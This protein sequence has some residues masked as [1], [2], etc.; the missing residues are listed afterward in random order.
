MHFPLKRTMVVDDDPLWRSNYVRHLQAFRY[1]ATECENEV[2]A[3]AC[4]SST[5][6]HVALVHFSE[7]IA[8]SLALINAI[9]T[10][11]PTISAIYA[12]AYD[13]Q[14]VKM[15]AW[16]QGAFAVFN[17]QAANPRGLRILVDEAASHSDSLRNF[18]LEGDDVFVLMPF[19]ARFN[20]RY[21][22]GIKEPLERLGYRTVRA[23]EVHASCDIVDDIGRRIAA[24]RFVVADMTGGNANV[25]YEVGMAHALRK[26]VILLTE[27]LA[28]LPFDLRGL[29]HV[30][31]G[32]ST[33][34]LREGLLA[35]V[36]DLTQPPPLN[37]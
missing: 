16:A 9:R 18:G 14:R 28:D 30:Q 13:G 27:R 20:E 4:V 1:E 26:Q 12:T 37:S 32:R 11:D 3:L 10:R 33:L 6:P 25:F 24:A 35:A 23:D 8:R 21:R 31:Y 2:E 34:R 22:L 17:K 5:R 36:A 29:R 15:Q 7:D 19:A